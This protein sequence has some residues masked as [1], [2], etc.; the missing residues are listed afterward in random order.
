M[1]TFI[2]YT[3]EQNATFKTQL[4]LKDDTGVG[5]NLVS[6]VVSS[7]VRRS[8]SSMNVATNIVC[9]MIDAPNGVVQL[10]ISY[11]NTANIKA[12]RYVYDV[13]ALN[14]STSEEL[15]LIEGIMTITPAVT[16]P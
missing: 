11:A 9:T 12:G 2:E 8:Y 6:Y 13:V 16:R 3:V 15:R 10:S 1:S 4:Q 14:N 5:L 7:Q